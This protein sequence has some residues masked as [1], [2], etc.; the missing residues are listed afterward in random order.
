MGDFGFYLREG[1]YHITDWKGYDH[2]LFVMAL[3]LPYFLKDWK[4]VLILITAFTIGHSLTLALSIFNKIL[5]PSTWIE[6]LIPITIIITA[7][8]NLFRNNN[9]PKHVRLRYAAAMLF[10]LI[11]GLGFSNYLRS[12]MGKSENIITQLLAFNIGL[13]LGQLLIVLVVLMVSFIFV[14]L[15]N[16]KQREWSLFIS[17]GI[18]GISFIMALERL[19][20]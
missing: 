13:E 2:I 20:F 7:L 6:F 12:M 18:F 11:H 3:C 15:L 1:F 4:Q 14:R 8:E 5:I 17:G 10:G 9:Q 19:P 16:I